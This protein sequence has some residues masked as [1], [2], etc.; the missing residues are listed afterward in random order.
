MEL[1]SLKKSEEKTPL[2]SS[3]PTNTSSHWNHPK[4]T[5]NA[6]RVHSNLTSA[7]FKSA[8]S[9]TTGGFA[10][11]LAQRLRSASS[12]TE[13]D[14]YGSGGNR[15]TNKESERGEDAMRRRSLD[16]NLKISPSADDFAPQNI[17]GKNRLLIM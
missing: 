16:P 4:G 1:N 11:N 6:P 2:L 13:A 8:N 7:L 10:S 9:N 3:S 15:S 17:S 12:G 14:F 5:S